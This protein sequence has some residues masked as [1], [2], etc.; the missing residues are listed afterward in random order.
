MAG[1]RTLPMASHD[2]AVMADPARMA[3]YARFVDVQR[4]LV[5]M[6]QASVA[7]GE[8]MLGDAPDV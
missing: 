8:A 7:Q 6:F 3:P 4:E 2:E 1:Y 5:G